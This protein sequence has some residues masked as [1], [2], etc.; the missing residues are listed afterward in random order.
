L[1]ERYLR[2]DSSLSKQDAKRKAKGIV[3]G[4]GFVP[5]MVDP[6]PGKSG[7]I[8]DIGL[9]HVLRRRVSERLAKLG[10][11]RDADSFTAGDLKKMLADDFGPFAHDSGVPIKSVSLLRTMK[12]PVVVPRRV[13]DYETMIWEV[14]KDDKAYR[15]HVGGN[16]H[17]LEIRE[18]A[19]GRWSGSVVSMKEASD[20]AKKLHVDPVDRSS[21]A[22]RGQFMM[23]LA[24]GEI[25]F[26]R[27]KGED[28]EPGR[29][30]YFVVVKLDGR[31]GRETAEFCAHWDARRAVG[32]KD[33][34]NQLIAGTKRRTFP[35]SPAQMQ[36]LAPPGHA[37]PVKVMITPLSDVYVVEPHVPL[38]V[39]QN[40][41]DPAVIEIAREGLSARRSR[42]PN[43]K[44]RRR[45][46]GSWSWM[47]AKLEKAGKKHLA[48]QLSAATRIL[49]DEPE[50]K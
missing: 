41:I 33:D 47:R 43:D 27:E 10:I 18:N 46:H 1:T 21:D 30:G 4:K 49:K 37:T 7:L 34:D 26:M 22:V 32:E 29:A 17:H 16:N 44:S 8:R 13:F 42:D 2:K 40:D 11:S 31:K 36:D 48:P 50:A 38:D 25:V 9:R 24:I 28:G 19:R 39:S 6:P 5:L 12:G 35:V 45:R 20:R 3:E 14:I 23:S 15:A